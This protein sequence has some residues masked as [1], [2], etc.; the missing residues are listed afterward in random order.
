MAE[1]G[2]TSDPYAGFRFVV[3]F[4][5][6]VAGVTEVSGLKSKTDFQKIRQGGDNWYAE[7]M[8]QPHQFPEMLTLKR[9]YFPKAKEY[10]DWIKAVHTPP[11]T[12]KDVTLELRNQDNSVVGT[13]QFYKC[14][15]AEYDGPSVSAKGGEIAVETIKIRYDYFTY[16]PK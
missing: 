14:V 15:P 10:F 7:V 6:A 3:N 8:V 5:G 9:V 12:R 2:P 16:A 11:Y 13:Y 4:G 1:S